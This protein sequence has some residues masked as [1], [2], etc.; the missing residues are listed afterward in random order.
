MSAAA[1]QI[2][3][4]GFQSDISIDERDALFFGV[5]KDVPA[6]VSFHGETYETLRAAMIETVDDYIDYVTADEE[7]LTRFVETGFGIDPV[8]GHLVR[9]A[10]VA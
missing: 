9:R 3:Y 7:V 8:S 6:S 2:S 4:R 5:L 10:E 1:R